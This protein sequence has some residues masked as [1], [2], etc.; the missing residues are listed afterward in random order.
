[1]N[2]V[3][4]K[5]DRLGLSVQNLDTQVGTQLQGLGQGRGKGRGFHRALGAWAH[6]MWPGV[7]HLLEPWVLLSSG[8]V[9]GRRYCQS[10]TTG[11]L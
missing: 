9:A 10:G 3:N 7:C 4:Q 6:P 1:M 11:I 8:D 2:F 5:L